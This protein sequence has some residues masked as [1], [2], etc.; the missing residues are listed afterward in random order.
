MRDNRVSR[1]QA[2][3]LGAGTLAALAGC[4]GSDDSGSTETAAETETATEET[5]TEEEMESYTV[6]MA[7]VGDVEFDSVPETWLS[8]FP[9]YADMGVALGHGEGLEAVGNV[10]R[11]HTDAYDELEGVSVNKDDLTQ[12]IGDGGI[13]KEL[14]YELGVDVHLT[15]PKW[16]TNNSFFGLGEDDVEEI[17]SN[18]SPFIGNTIF[19]R[20]DTWHDYRYYSLYGAFEKVA[21]IFQEQERYEALKSF[22]DDY[23]AEVQSQLPSADQRPNALLTFGAG[24]QPDEFAPYRLT[25]KGTNKKQWHDL[26]I[27]DALAGTGIEGLSTTE[28][29]Y[30]D[31]ETMLEVDP[32]VILMRGQETKT[33][34]EFQDTVVSYMKDHNVAS[35]LTAVKNDRVFRGGPIYQ[36]PIQHL[37]NLE[38]AAKQLFPDTFEGELFDRDRVAEIVVDGE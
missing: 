38:R 1:R 36:G 7:P 8:Y 27:S 21:E 19:R 24:D 35:D 17:E 23:V 31:F 26:G 33:R 22:H 4:T 11:Y 34:E 3:T 28:R 15:D 6:S 25:D 14:Y 13:D 5:A 37:F 20:T 30:I 12:L 29:G 10:P 2:L 16:L 18:V 32:D 9:G